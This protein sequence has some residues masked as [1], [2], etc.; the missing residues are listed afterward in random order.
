[1]LFGTDFQLKKK[2]GNKPK[3]NEK[4]YDISHDLQIV[5]TNASNILLKKLNGKDREKYKKILES[6]DFENY[7]AIRDEIKFARYKY[8]E[9]NF[10]NRFLK[11]KGIE[12]IIIPSNIIDIYTRQEILPG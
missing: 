6:L 4:I 7:K 1:M 3:I 11:G 10:K 9:I 8:S 5:F 12:K 2:V